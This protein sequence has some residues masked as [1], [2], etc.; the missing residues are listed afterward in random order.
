MEEKFLQSVVAYLEIFTASHPRRMQSYNPS[1][2]ELN[3]SQ[4]V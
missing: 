4:W 2:G 1:V 3:I